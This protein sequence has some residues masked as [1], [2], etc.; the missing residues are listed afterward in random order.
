MRQAYPGAQI[1]TFLIMPDKSVKATQ[2]R[3]NQL[4]KIVRDGKKVR[5]ADLVFFP[6]LPNDGCGG[7]ELI[8]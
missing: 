7:P 6:F 3:L 1:S 5:V 8:A 4:F 2:D